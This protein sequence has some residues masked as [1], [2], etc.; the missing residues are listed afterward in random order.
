MA[1]KKPSVMSPSDSRGQLDKNA[2]GFPPTMDFK[3]I[4]QENQPPDQTAKGSVTSM[5]SVKSNT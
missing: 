4:C 3:Q 2:G 5:G 1:D